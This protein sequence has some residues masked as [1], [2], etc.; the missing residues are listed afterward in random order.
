MLVKGKIKYI[1]I[2]IMILT[3]TIAYFLFTPKGALRFATLRY[4]YP[5]TSLKLKITKTPFKVETKENEEIYT[6][7][8]PPTDKDTDSQLYN[9]I[10]RKHKYIY[11]GEY[12]GW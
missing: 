2:L 9:W 10:I 5:L 3:M 12:Y 11:W 8:N 7:S 6:I 4:G 1:I